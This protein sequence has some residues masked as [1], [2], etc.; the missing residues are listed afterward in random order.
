[1]KEAKYIK[2]MFYKTIYKTGEDKYKDAVI[3]F[4]TV[5]YDDKSREEFV[6]LNKIED[7]KCDDVWLEILS[8]KISN[9]D[10][11]LENNNE[12]KNLG[13]YKENIDKV[14]FYEPESII[15]EG[16]LDTIDEIEIFSVGDETDNLSFVV[17]H[18]SVSDPYC[19]T[20]NSDNIDIILNK[21]VVNYDKLVDKGKISVYNL[22]NENEVKENIT[23]I[24]F[25]VRENEVEVIAAKQ[26]DSYNDSSYTRL[27]LEAGLAQ[28]KNNKNIDAKYVKIVDGKRVN[29]SE[30]EFKDI[31]DK[32]NIKNVCESELI[33]EEATEDQFEDDPHLYFWDKEKKKKDRVKIF[34]GVLALVGIG[35]FAL[36]P[37]SNKTSGKTPVK[38]KTT[39]ENDKSI[40]TSSDVIVGPNTESMVYTTSSS[41]NSQ[42][43]VKSD[44]TTTITN[45][46]T[47]KESS[48]TNSESITTTITTTTKDNSTTTNNGY[49]VTV[50]PETK[51]TGTYRTV[52]SS[53][54]VPSKTGTNYVTKTTT[55]GNVTYKTV[56]PK[57][58]VTA[59]SKAGE[60]VF[61]KD[62]ATTTKK[63][64]TTI[65]NPYADLIITNDIKSDGKTLVLKR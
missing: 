38:T 53:D 63:T 44:D 41:D 54:M 47:T 4:T 28:I 48:V 51:Y 13:I 42:S 55:N 11:F 23:N 25:I 7:N 58:M 20:C 22:H 36:W 32:I 19:I 12:W 37:N 52:N 18:D 31:V 40:T 61:T 14:K 24:T 3:V 49:T 27:P 29:I 60:Q 62:G 5:R 57:D 43:T 39:S 64:S 16:I 45:K 17:L 10:N 34:A 46:T 65:K 15:S 50:K 9:Y 1:M 35:T 2:N 59:P 26:A 8:K 56:D 30:E 33:E 6:T 21:L